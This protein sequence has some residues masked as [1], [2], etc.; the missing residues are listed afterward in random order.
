[1]RTKP[2]LCTP[3]RPSVEQRRFTPILTLYV[4]LRNKR[5]TLAV[6]QLVA[7]ETTSDVL[8]EFLEFLDGLDLGVKAVY[9]D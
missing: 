6:R 1:M 3:H 9:L 5:Y 2:R 8:G 7:G 4:R